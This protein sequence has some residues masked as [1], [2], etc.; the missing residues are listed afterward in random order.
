MVRPDRLTLKG[1]EAFRD[2]LAD[3]RARGNPV[4][5]DAH[6][7][8]ALL[9]QPEGVV[10]PLLQKAGVN[11]TDLTAQVTREIDRFP[12]QSGEAGEPALS[13]EV[14]GAFDRAEREAKALGDAFVST[15]HLLL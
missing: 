9:A 8:L 1:Q 2:A 12:T 7:L 6:L 13:R 14:N 11:V 10:R 4:A 5:N 3:A 15:E